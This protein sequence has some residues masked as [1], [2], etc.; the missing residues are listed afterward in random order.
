MNKLYFYICILIVIILYLFRVDISVFFGMKKGITT[1]FILSLLI[2][3]SGFRRLYLGMNFFNSS[4]P[5]SKKNIKEI[6]EMF[7]K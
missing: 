3:I 1:L 7:T 5:F 2:F 6:K 4:Y